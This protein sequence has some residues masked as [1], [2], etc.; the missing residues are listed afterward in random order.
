MGSGFARAAC[1]P[2]TADVSVVI[3]VYNHDCFIGAAIDSVL[4][5][6]VQPREILCI[7]DGSTDRSAQTVEALAARHANVHF[8]SRPNHGAARTINEGIRAARGRY[9]AILNSD[10]LYHPARLQ[11]CL[12]VLDG[13]PGAAVVATDVSFV[14]EDGDAIRFP[15]YEEVYAFYEKIGD[16][17]L[18]LANG[19]F[20]MTTSNIVARRPVF[21]EVGHFDDLRYAHDLDF[22]LRLLVHGRR[23]VHLPEP[24]L[25]YRVHRSNTVSQNLAQ[26]RLETAVVAAFFARRLASANGVASHEPRYLSRLL[27]VIERQQL[28]RVVALAL[29]H[30]EGG[31]AGAPSPAACLSDVAFRSE[32]SSEMATVEVA[33]LPRP[34]AGGASPVSDEAS[35]AHNQPMSA[36][37][38]TLQ[39]LVDRILR[40]PLARRFFASVRW[41]SGLDADLEELRSRLERVEEALG[42][43][44]RGLEAAGAAARDAAVKTESSVGK[45][46]EWYKDLRPESMGSFRYGDTVTYRI[47]SAFLADVGEV[48]D[49]GC[50]AGGFKRFYRGRY[51]GIDG[52]RTPF[53]DRVVDLCTYASHVEGIVMRH[54]LEHNYRWQEILDAAVRSFTRKFCLIL[55]T[56]FAERTQQIAHNKQHGVD[57]PDLSFSRAD[58]EA[59][60]GG[61]RWELFDNIPTDSGYKAEHVYLIWREGENQPGPSDGLQ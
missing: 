15:W 21:D 30:A 28:T 11:R 31:G 49:W 13:D 17:G 3:P 41:R 52:S 29:L 51:I 20:L 18:G 57:V 24:L 50:G 61:L 5:Q 43:E 32:A 25:T 54:V 1:D 2:P 48:E 33:E 7:D 19:N 37:S 44:A 14:N 35:S 58:I 22:F 34:S 46:D 38:P 23:L 53:A 56:P 60:L 9:V 40:R 36:N 26:V 45:W 4:S 55:F 8:W 27:G 42:V 6:T 47:A 12:A 10:D 59:R 16:L 39:R